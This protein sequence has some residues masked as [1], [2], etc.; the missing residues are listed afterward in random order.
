MPVSY[1]MGCYL[2][3][4]ADQSNQTRLY[5]NESANGQYAAKGLSSVFGE[6]AHIGEFS[7]SDVNNAEVIPPGGF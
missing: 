4:S 2:V 5:R 6:H 3:R 7:I 1:T